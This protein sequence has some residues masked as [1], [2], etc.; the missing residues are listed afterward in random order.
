MISIHFVG[1]LFSVVAILAVMSSSRASPRRAGNDHQLDR[2]EA[3]ADSGG[4][5][6]DGLVRG[7]RSRHGTIGSSSKT[8]RPTSTTRVRSIA[9]GSPGRSTWDAS[10]DRGPVS[11]VRER[12]R[13]PNR[14][15]EGTA[16]GPWA[17][18]RDGQV[19]A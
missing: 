1:L 10:R 8:P 7:K 12:H 3:G 13:L 16:R 18:M 17:W 9:C 15:R 4:G 19:R 6:H 11:A 2:Y 14:C 5:V